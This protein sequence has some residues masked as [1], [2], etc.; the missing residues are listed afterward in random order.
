MRSKNSPLGQR[1]LRVGEMVRH[2]LADI[3]ER[4]D[5][6]DPV[7]TRVS[8]TVTEVRLT[9]DLRQATVFVMPL[10]GADADGVMT[11]LVRARKHLRHRL[12]EK[13][14]L[15][16]LPDLFFRLDRSFAEA[17][18]VEALLRSPEVARDLEDSSD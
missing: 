10:G 11:A 13:V 9:P 14:E 5:L 7:L 18:R 1:Q 3:L 15:R 17:E 8:V 16:Y 4:G 2:A 12:G 6:H